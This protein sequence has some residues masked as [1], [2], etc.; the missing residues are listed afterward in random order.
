MIAFI[1]AFLLLGA[2]LALLGFGW[3]DWLGSRTPN[4][5][6]LPHVVLAPLIGLLINVISWVWSFGVYGGHKGANF[7]TLILA[8]GGY[9][10]AAISRRI[11]SRVQMEQPSIRKRRINLVPIL[12]PCIA[13][14]IAA[15]PSFQ[16]ATNFNYPARVGPDALGYAVSARVLNQSS[17]YTSLQ[18]EIEKRTG[19]HLAELLA[20]DDPAVYSVPSFT[21]QIATEY[22]LGASRWSSIGLV[23]SITQFSGDAHAYQAMNVLVVLAIALAMGILYSALR[24][25][26]V[27]PF[28]ASV[29]TTLLAVSPA[30]LVAWHDGFFAHTLVLPFLTLGI[31][32]IWHQLST[33]KAESNSVERALLPLMT[34]AIAGTMSLYLDVSFFLVP[35]IVILLGL[36]V[37]HESSRSLGR[38]LSQAVLL[39]CIVSTV[40][41]LPLVLRSIR[42]IINQLNFK[43]GGYWQPTWISPLEVLGFI[44]FFTRGNIFAAV[45]RSSTNVALP[46]QFI[47]WILGIALLVGITRALRKHPPLQCFNIAML[48]TVSMVYLQ[49]DA[50]HLNNYQYFKAVSY[51]LVPLLLILTSAID[52]GGLFRKI[53]GSKSALIAIIAIVAT[54]LSV[55]TLKFSPTR[56]AGTY[57]AEISR[58]GERPSIS[59]YLASHNILTAGQHVPVGSLAA[60]TDIYWMYRGAG[61]MVTDFSSRLEKPIAWLLFRDTGSGLECIT[62]IAG[63]PDMAAPSGAFV[64]YEIAPNSL[65]A[66]ASGGGATD[67]LQ[68]FLSSHQLGTVLSGWRSSVCSPGED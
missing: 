13:L 24:Q 2:V 55:Y 4:A 29:L 8:L 47:S 48:A 31:S 3:S 36:L 66:A 22:L 1:L 40:M 27:S 46:M 5:F 67:V 61:G 50:R 30:T 63:V 57:S 21:D 51:A 16:S 60:S 45:R 34:I 9:V 53:E 43:V 28:A 7:L 19:Y 14:L 59:N 6:S 10:S 49:S 25:S 58:D 15:S 41:V 39:S 65:D 54:S 17:N 62:S 20:P 12:L 44:N 52:H 18:T 23:A 56:S 38:K 32:V 42:P 37:G 11:G 35:F 68:R 64:L 26:R 33:N